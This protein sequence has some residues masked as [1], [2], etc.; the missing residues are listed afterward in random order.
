MH[1]D[2]CT[3]NRIIF[4]SGSLQQVGSLAAELG[5]RVLVVTG[6][7]VERADGLLRLL[8]KENLICDCFSV[9][10]EPTIET[11][12]RGLKAAE[13]QK[14]D[15]VIGFGGGSVIDSGKAIAALSKNT[16][17]VLDY[18]EVIG[19]GQPLQHAPAPYIAIPTTAGTGA[20]VTR[21]AVLKST[22]HAVKVSLRSP[23]MLPDIAL[24]DPEL[25]L[26]MP[27]A[28]TAATGMD[29]LTQLLEALVSKKSNPL[30]DGICREGLKRS[31]TSLKRA[32][33]EPDDLKARNDMALSSLFS[34]LAL[35][36]A[37]L[38]AVHGIAGP[39]GGMCAAPHGVACAR[40]LPYVTETNLSALRKGPFDSRSL[41]R[42]RDASRLLTA[43]DHADED[44]LI[45]WLHELLREFQIPSLA[46]YGLKKEQIPQLVKQSQQASSMKGNPVELKAAEL[47][48]IIRCAF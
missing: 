47:E 3:A 16:G 41:M 2:F 20:E 23:L 6:G 5:N 7:K 22:R 45:V 30:T 37:G 27:P 35:A 32:F 46:A 33:R 42:Y 12:M 31:A 18:I 11:M 29:A 1:F 21:N 9:S 4:G 39:L 17:N 25:T 36:N 43:N 14:C 15:L 19:N 28:V 34:G 8:R 13:R 10:G 26:S 38:G 44:E 24:V 40:L 48:N